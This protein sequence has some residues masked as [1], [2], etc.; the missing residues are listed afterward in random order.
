MKYLCSDLH[1]DYF[2]YKKALDVV[3]DNELIII[4]DAIDRGE[5]G[6]DILLDTMQRKNVTLMMGNHEA[7]MA[8]YL[9]EKG[10]YGMAWLDF[11]N[12]GDATYL[13]YR[14]KKE[15]NGI[16]DEV[17]CDYL[18]HLP[19]AIDYG[20]VYLVHGKPIARLKSDM[21]MYENPVFFYMD[22][23]TQEELKTCI[24]ESFFREDSF[25]D[26]KQSVRGRVDYFVGHV[27]TQYAEK[28]KMVKV[29][30]SE[31]LSLKASDGSVMYDLDGG[32]AMCS[33]QSY[34]VLY[35]LDTDEVIHIR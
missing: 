22:D 11:R 4:G 3:G 18:T 35:C 25:K 5:N 29:G 14:Q 9:Y 32:C 27:I 26:Y 13:S 33:P 1:G 23:C 21:A 2:K 17:L 7:M 8:D 15:K 30:E 19:V 24:W 28:G 10:M 12:G 20:K 16:N 31:V 6:L 34:L